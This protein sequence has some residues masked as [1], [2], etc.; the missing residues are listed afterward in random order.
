MMHQLDDDEHTSGTIVPTFTTAVRCNQ[1]AQQHLRERERYT[2]ST[3][4]DDA[5][6]FGRFFFPA[7]LVGHKKIV[8][9]SSKK[10]EGGEG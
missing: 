7:L 2:G 9:F 10:K 4:Y 5:R 6:Y 8:A 1:A 3:G